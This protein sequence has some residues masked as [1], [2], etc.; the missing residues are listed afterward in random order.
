[1]WA[2]WNR[3]LL[4]GSAGSRGKLPQL[5]LIREVGVA[6]CHWRYLNK[7]TCSPIHLKGT[8]KKGIVTEH[9]L[10]VLLHPWEHTRPAAATAKHSR[11]YLHA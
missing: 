6:H 5:S 10:L 8:T 9:H 11:Q 2:K 1:M 7:I 3:V 4:A